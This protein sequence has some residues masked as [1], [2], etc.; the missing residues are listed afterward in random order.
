MHKLLS[1][2][3]KLA[4]VKLRDLLETNSID[5]VVIGGLAATAW[6]SLRQVADFDIQVDKRNLLKTI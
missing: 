4:L 3:Q 6:G 2:D 1:D 5:F